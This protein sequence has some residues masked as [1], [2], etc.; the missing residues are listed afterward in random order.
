MSPEA[1]C[2]E[3]NK[4]IGSQGHLTDIGVQTSYLVPSMAPI[5]LAYLYRLAKFTL[6]KQTNKLSLVMA[7]CMSSV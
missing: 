2:L 3:P 7:L 1:S 6:E 4:P 5:V